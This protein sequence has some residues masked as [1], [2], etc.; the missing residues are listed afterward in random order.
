MLSAALGAGGV[1]LQTSSEKGPNPIHPGKFD[2]LRPDSAHFR[3]RDMLSR[4]SARASKP[5]QEAGL[6]RLAAGTEH[7]T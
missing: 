1:L 3:K 2:R 6:A 7:E 5:L 4:R